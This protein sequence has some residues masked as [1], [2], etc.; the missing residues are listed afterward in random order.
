MRITAEGVPAVIEAD[1]DRLRQVLANL[2]ANSAAA[3]AG[4]ARIRIEVD[5]DW[6]RLRWADDGP[7][8]DPELL[9]TAFERFVRGDASRASATGAGLGLPIV[10]AVLAA[11]GGTAAIRN[12][13]PLGGG[14]VILCL[15]LT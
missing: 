9:G 8:F 7:G 10:R 12:G 1:A 4:E 15:P 14:V 3:G 6:T 2:A 11:H 5:R 13:P